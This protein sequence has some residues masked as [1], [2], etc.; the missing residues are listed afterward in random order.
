MRAKY[1]FSIGKRRSVL[2][3]MGTVLAANSSDEEA[4]AEDDL[5]ELLSVSRR[6]KSK[7]NR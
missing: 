6:V 3:K 7:N 1:L 5:T 2:P 4:E